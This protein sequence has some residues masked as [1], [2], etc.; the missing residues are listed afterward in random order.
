MAFRKGYQSLLSLILR[1]T[2][3]VESLA[4]YLSSPG[5]RQTKSIKTLSMDMNP[6]YI[7]AVRSGGKFHVAK[8]LCVV[9]DKTRQPEMKTVP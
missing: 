3:D 1:D 7:S 8:V 9:V 5:D 4:G 2:P 6:G